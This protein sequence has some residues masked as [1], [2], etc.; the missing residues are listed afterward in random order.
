MA[1]KTK[2]K[3]AL[4]AASDV[5]AEQVQDQEPDPAVPK[6]D[7]EEA[8]IKVMKEFQKALAMLSGKPDLRGFPILS[9]VEFST[10]VQWAIEVQD[11]AR[12][13]QSRTPALEQLMSDTVLRVLG[14]QWEKLGY[15]RLPAELPEALKIIFSLTCPTSPVEK[16][17]IFD[18]V[19]MDPTL[20]TVDAIYEYSFRF[21]FFAHALDFSEQQS[22]NLLEAFVHGLL[23]PLA[24]VAKI[25]LRQNPQGD[26]NDLVEHLIRHAKM[27]HEVSQSSST[28]TVKNERDRNQQLRVTRPSRPRIENVPLCDEHFRRDLCFYCHRPGHH[29]NDCPTRPRSSPAK[30]LTDKPTSLRFQNRSPVQHRS[31]SPEPRSTFSSTRPSISRE[32]PQRPS[33]TPRKPESQAKLLRALRHDLANQEV[34]VCIPP[35]IPRSPTSS[36][37]VF[38]AEL[39]PGAN[40]SIINEQLAHQLG[41]SVVECEPFTI[42][43]AQPDLAIPIR[44]KL[45]HLLPVQLTADA[46][47]FMERFYVASPGPG[48]GRALVGTPVLTNYYIY[49]QNKILHYHKLLPEG[50][51]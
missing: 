5:E 9:S 20:S 10:V 46:I 34:E 40:I 2:A 28:A 37:S 44:K 3:T 48:P 27:L 39:D 50:L 45:E 25:L 24:G 21:E 13:A 19:R 26:L 12:R 8:Q 38:V 1:T 51:T 18:S 41:L 30:D 17:I 49:W 29:L 15:Q 31:T 47:P 43:M 14:R 4:L 6:D 35:D 33:R 36:V 11:Q 16:A 32:Q 42:M 7:T 23:Q 22:K